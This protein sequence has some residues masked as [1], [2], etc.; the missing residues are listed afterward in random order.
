MSVADCTLDGVTMTQGRRFA[1]LAAPLHVVGGLAP[2]AIFSRN[3]VPA[4]LVAT[5]HLGVGRTAAHLVDSRADAQVLALGRKH[6]VQGRDDPRLSRKERAMI[7]RTEEELAAC[8]NRAAPGSLVEDSPDSYH[9]AACDVTWPAIYEE[10]DLTKCYECHVPG[11]RIE[12][13]AQETYEC[14]ECEAVWH[15]ADGER[16]MGPP[17]VWSVDDE[18]EA[19][20][21]EYLDRLYPPVTPEDLAF[22]LAHSARLVVGECLDLE[23]WGEI[24]RH[25]HITDREGFCLDIAGPSWRALTAALRR[26]CPHGP[27]RFSILQRVLL[28]EGILRRGDLA[29]WVTV[30]KGRRHVHPAV[31]E[32]FARTPAHELE[33]SRFADLIRKTASENQSQEMEHDPTE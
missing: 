15:I 9:C 13:F 11:V 19:A 31:L 16:E 2:E 25:P 30:E 3:G 20:W 7:V 4:A 1:R 14:L 5:R 28:L 23:E 10:R 32:V 29:D 33:E 17:P 18:P 22:A 21:F 6:A 8:P 12:G 27:T 26:H 24:R